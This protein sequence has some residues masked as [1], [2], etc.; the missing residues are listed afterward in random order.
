M[1]IKREAREVVLRCNQFI[2]GYGYWIFETK[3][4]R[5]EVLERMTDTHYHSDFCE[6]RIR[7][8]PGSSLSHKLINETGVV[9]EYIYFNP[10]QSTI[11][12]KSIEQSG[13]RMSFAKIIS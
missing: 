12:T 6:Y 3:S 8:M 9:D 7:I 5:I 2:S 4:G 11:E 13:K 1:I 10:D